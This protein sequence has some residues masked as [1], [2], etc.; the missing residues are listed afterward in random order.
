MFVSH[1]DWP[2]PPRWE[3]PRPPP[4]KRMSAAGEKFLLWVVGVNLLLLFVAP[5]AGA[6]MVQLLWM[7]ME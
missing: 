5:I 7:L 6:S 1:D 4:R 3:P 2:P